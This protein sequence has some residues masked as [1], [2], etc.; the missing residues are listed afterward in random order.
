[1]H[2]CKKFL[3]IC[4]VLEPSGGGSGRHVLDLSRGLASKGH[5]VT[6]IWSPV[7]AKPDWI[8]SMEAIPNVRTLKLDMQRSVG[9]GDFLVLLRLKT[10]LREQGPFDIIHG[11]S[12]KAGALIRLLPKSI[13]GHRVY[14][15]HAYITMN[16]SLGSLKRFIYKT[17]EQ[18]L[19]RG[20]STTIAVSS[21]ESTHAEA[22]GIA[23]S[24]ETI[25]NGFT[26]KNSSSRIQARAA[27]GAE[28][29]DFLV[30]FIGRLT[31]QKNPERYVSVVSEAHKISPRIK[32][33]VIGD[34][35]LGDVAKAEA[36]LNPGVFNFM[37]WQN[38]LELL[39][40][41]DAYLM[42]SRY[43]AMP[44]TLLEA[45]AHGLPIITTRVGGAR[46][47]I[48]NEK[49][50]YIFEQADADTKIGTSLSYLANSAS[51]YKSFSDASLQLATVLTVEKMVEGTLELYTRRA[52]PE[53]LVI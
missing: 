6:I 3:R 10:I 2:K 28:K 39:P 13:P 20:E 24:V 21:D 34:G 25:V 49:N 18:G 15:P 43:E 30:G 47:T 12:S 17:I 36:E 37:G 31:H 8:R 38:A 4:L 32:G 7:R 42:T 19:S 48:K 26:R 16:P 22:L 52:G 51:L 11:H 50:G 53:D 45:L 5:D 41:L 46:E 9:P 14:T 23:P 44:Y 1:M 29:D 35:E 40:G 33:V 27:M